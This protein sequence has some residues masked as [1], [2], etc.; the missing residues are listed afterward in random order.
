MHIELTDDQSDQIVYSE[1]QNT[2][3]SLKLSLESL[4][5]GKN[6]GLFSYDD[7]VEKEKLEKMIDALELSSTW[8]EIQ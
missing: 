6:D 3:N 7:I 5:N 4:S 2:V 8:F 1:L